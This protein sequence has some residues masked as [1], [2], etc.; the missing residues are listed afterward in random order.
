MRK[1]RF[2]S[3]LIVFGCVLFSLNMALNIMEKMQQ[4]SDAQNSLK[5]YKERMSNPVDALDPTITALNVNNGELIIPKLDVDC[6]IRSDTVNAYDAVYHYPE[7]SGYGQPGECAILGHRTTYSGIFRNIG[8]LAPG[9]EVIIKD[10]ILKKKYVYQVT[11]IGDDIRWDYKSNPVRFAQEGEPR[12]LLMTCYPPG[13][14]SAAWITHCKLVIT[15]S[16]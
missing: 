7:S 10:L 2:I 6:S 15:S 9:D 1:Y 3:L 13:E 11:S 12:L 8:S 14:K 5:A 16:F 4:V